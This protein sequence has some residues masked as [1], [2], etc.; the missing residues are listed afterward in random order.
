MDKNVF[1]FKK[2]QVSHGK[3]S[4]KIGVDAVLLGCWA[5]RVCEKILEVGTGC[6]VISLILAQRFPT[7]F[8]EAIDIDESSVE[9]AR[10]NFENSPWSQRLK[11]QR[12]CFPKETCQKENLYDLIVSNP[13]YFNSGIDRPSTPREIARHQGELSIF[14]LIENS[15]QLLKSGGCL[16]MIFPT[17]FAERA[18]ECGKIHG[19]SLTRL[20]YIRNNPKS[21]EKR[22]MM[23]LKK[24][25]EVEESPCEVTHINLFED[26]NPTDD[27]IILCK[28]FY[29][30]F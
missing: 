2:F 20:C 7:S 26:G 25:G 12:E 23:E 29:L 4:M 19:L 3:S 18:I 21:R 1:Q 22:V 17:E 10:K 9:E 13:P 14:S 30:K 11:V 15:S 5:G 24:M 16:S 27:H 6:G 28:D 8:I